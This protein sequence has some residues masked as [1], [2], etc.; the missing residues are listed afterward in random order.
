M[1]IPTHITDEERSASHFH[2]SLF[3]L[4][5]LLSDS[6]LVFVAYFCLIHRGMKW[7]QFAV[8]KDSWLLGW[9]AV[10]QCT[11][12]FLINYEVNKAVSMCFNPSKYGCGYSL[13]FQPRF[14]YFAYL[15]KQKPKHSTYITRHPSFNI[16]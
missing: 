11:I 6:V 4:V 3:L 13:P 10:V 9:L 2:F 8:K 12:G 1:S 5:F 14:F 15:R 16:V 7:L